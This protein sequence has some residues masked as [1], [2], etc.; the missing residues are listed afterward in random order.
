MLAVDIDPD[1]AATAQRVLSSNSGQA[2][3]QVENLS[4]FGLDP[5]REGTFDIVY[6]WGVLHHTG[7]MWHAVEKAASMVA[8]G[9]LLAIALYRTTRLDAF[10]K[11]EKRI[12]ASAPELVQRLI[13]FGYI[14]AF[15]LGK[16]ATGDNFRRYVANYR[17]SRGMDFYH[18]VH[19]WLGG[20]PY[21]TVLA[22]GVDEKLKSLGFAAERVIARPI[23]LG[24]FGSGCDEFVY[25]L[26]A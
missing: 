6:S 3:W 24:L 7:D 1:S 5:A 18:D 26:K 4:V 15:R 12:Y 8:P 23:S 21:E 17:S 25:R 14:L 11:I 10:W 2:P 19:D 20:Y 13:R 16:L 9:G 22:A